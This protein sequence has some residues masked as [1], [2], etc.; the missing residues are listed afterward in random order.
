MFR[1]QKRIE[2][3]GA[4]HLNLPYESKCRN[5]HGHSWILTIYCQASDEAVEANN[6]MVIDFTNIKEVVMR[7]DHSDLN[8][9]LE[10]NPTAENI[11]RWICL[12]TPYC[13]QVD[14]Q[15]S[16]GN[17]ATYVVD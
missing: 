2:I 17:I 1:I 15:E 4:H 12:H 10:E 5:V 16:E 14:V 11:A 6:G 9:I 13:Y 3:A 8:Q 7:L